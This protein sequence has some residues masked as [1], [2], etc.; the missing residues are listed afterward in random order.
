M[1]KTITFQ[2]LGEFQSLPEKSRGNNKFPIDNA[3]GCCE[4]IYIKLF[5]NMCNSEIEIL[6]QE[7]NKL[8]LN[9][10]NQVLAKE[11]PNQV[12]EKLLSQVNE[13]FVTGTA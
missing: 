9:E 13:N 10:I 3:L 5:K 8:V 7:L 1:F 2:I 11:F 4:S 12:V 6:K